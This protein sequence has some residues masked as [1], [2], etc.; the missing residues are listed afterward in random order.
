[1]R[2]KFLCIFL[3]LLFVLGVTSCSQNKDSTAGKDTGNREIKVIDVIGKEVTLKAPAKKV[4]G[5]HNP[6]LNTVV[7]IG[8]GGKYLAG[9]GNK[10]MARGLYEN[11]IDGYNDLPQ[12]G[13]G[14]DINMETV[15]G[16][17]ADLAVIP[18]R[19]ASQAETYQSSDVPALVVLPND[20]NFDTVSNALKIV[21]KAL[22]EDQRANDITSF[23]DTKLNEISDKV[24]SA[25]KKPSILFL[26]GTNALSVAPNAMIQTYIIEKAGGKNAVSG[27][28][29][30]G[31]FADVSIEEIIEW[32][33]DIIWV[34]SYAKYSVD[35]LLNDPAWSS[36]K[37]VQDKAVYVF[38]SAME[39]W[40]YPTASS[41]LGV[42]WAANNLH[43]D[44]YNT[45]SFMKDVDAFYQM[46]YGKTFT[47]EQLGLH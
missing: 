23:I 6:S 30:K 10:D 44:L 12:I 46:V 22:G 3:T 9:F 11:V 42:C 28:D 37:A 26:G 17:G 20:E 24:A 1:M 33:P 43:G 47:K 5:T 18:E 29:K 35:D 41:I 19:F 16:L 40:D 8:G 15:V 38:P 21:G 4:V 39:P 2:K 7:V 36:I 34:P 25:P 45:D 32:N 27:I 13:K 31:E 14:K